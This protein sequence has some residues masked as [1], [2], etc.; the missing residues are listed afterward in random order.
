MSFTS[1]RL[2]EERA[3]PRP[4]TVSALEAVPTGVRVARGW[5]GGYAR[6][7][8][9][10]EGERRASRMGRFFRVLCISLVAVFLGLA[11]LGGTVKALV[12]M[13]VITPQRILALTGTDLPVD[14]DGFTN[15]LL[16]GTGDKDHEGIDLTDTMI[17]VSLDPKGTKS[18]VML[19]IPRD[20]YV[21]KT[22]RLGTGR[23][24]ELYRNGK[25]TLV[26]KGETEA[27]ASQEAMRELAAE[28]GRKLGMTI[29]HVAKVNFTAFTQ[30]VDALGGVD[31]DVPETIVDPEYPGPN[32][33]Y[34]TFTIEAGQH[35]MDGETALKYARSR[36]STSD[37]DRSGRQQLIIKALAEKASAQGVAT[38]PGKLS[39]LFKILSENVET[40]M[41]FGEILGAG[42]IAEELDR[43]NIISVHLDTRTDIPGGFLY[44]PPRDQ[45]GGAAVLLPQ[46]LGTEPQGSWRQLQVLM[47]VLMRNRAMLL[48]PPQLV[49][50]NAGARTGLAR[51][52]AGELTRFDFPVADVGNL[53]DSAKDKSLN[54][55]VSVVVPKTPADRAAAEFFASLLRLPLGDPPAPS[56]LPGVITGSGAVEDPLLAKYGQ[57]TILLGEDYAF[58]PLQELLPAPEEASSS[59]GPTGSGSLSSPAR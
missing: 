56:S 9:R 7:K 46:N 17:V 5:W 32:Y 45:F 59:S 49:I 40:T 41:N 51:I 50:R 20:L 28:L 19:S 29:H 1:R 14:A 34:E 2:S 38:S 13:K 25:W 12:A 31:I 21:T 10:K 33:S 39:A 36:H 3:K 37:F 11:V 26:H 24:N 35:H 55:A 16:L 52:L 48:T 15:F 18:A 43:A 47:G 54:R 27:Q 44:A 58:T 42:K 8:A 30:A 53:A 22:E 23:V 4:K 57:V 6:W